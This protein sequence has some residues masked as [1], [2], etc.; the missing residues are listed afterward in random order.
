[1][2]Q[3]KNYAAGIHI[4]K[5]YFKINITVLTRIHMRKHKTPILILSGEEE[6]KKQKKKSLY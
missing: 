5:I 2:T 3:S 1:M 4:G 6:N